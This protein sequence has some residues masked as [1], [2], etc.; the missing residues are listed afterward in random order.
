M[1]NRYWVGGTASWDGTAGTKW[2]ETSGGPGGASVP[3]VADD[4]FIDANS[5]VVTVTIATGNT[6]AKSINCTGFT[7]TVTG[8]ASITV[9][10]S[11]T[12][13]SAM[14]YT[15]TG[16]ML[17]I[18]TGTLTT[19][20]KTINGV[21]VNGDG[22][23][24]TLGSAL[25]SSN[26][27]VIDSG[28][29]DTGNYSVITTTLRSIGSAIR[30]INFGSS[31]ITLTSDACINFQNS[32]NLTL[33]AGTS[34]IFITA[35]NAEIQFIGNGQTF[36]NVNF[37]TQ[38]PLITIFD[39]N[40]F[41]NLS[42]QGRTT[43]GVSTTIFTANQTING[44]LTLSAGTNSS[45]RRVIASDVTGTI[46]TLTCN[47]VA[48][49][50]DIDFCDIAFAGN[51]ISGG[52][53][54]GT[55]LGNGK[56]NSNITF[57][58]PKT[59]YYRATGSANWGS[60]TSWSL[61]SGGTAT[62]AAFPLA[63]DSVIFPA[64][65]YPATGSTT[66]INGNY[67]VTTI[68]MSLRTA[69]TMSLSVLTGEGIG[70]VV[71]GN[72]ING[73][74]TTITNATSTVKF[75]GRTAQTITTAEKTFGASRSITIDSP[76]GSVTLNGALT[77]ATL[78]VT[79]GTFDTANFNV[80]ATSLS[81]SNT[82]VRTITLGSSVVE[83]LA[84]GSSINFTNSTNLTF[85][86]NT[87]QINLSASAAQLLGGGMTFYN[88]S[89]TNT[90]V[91]TRSI[92][93]E[94]T[95]NNL[96]LSTVSPGIAQLSIAADQIING[97]LTCAGSTALRRGFVSSNIVGTVRTI[98]AASISANDCDFRDITLAGAAAGAS[99]TRAG[100][101]GGNSGI[102]FPAP[103]TVYRVENITTWAGANSWSLTSGGNGSDNNF[104]L[105]QDTAVID[106]STT[107]TGT[108]AFGV[109]Y[110]VSAIDCSSRTSAI[111]LNHNVVQ[112]IYGSYTLGSGVTV[113]GTSQQTFSGRGTMAITSAGKTI[114]FPI[115]VETYG[116]TFQLND[117]FSS[118]NFVIIIAGAFDANNYNLSAT[119]YAANFPNTRTINM[120]S[121]LW[122]LS[123]A[124][125][126]AASAP[127][128]IN[129]TTGL[130]F[131]KGTANILLSNNTTSARVFIG[132]G[133]SYNKLT[134][135]GNTSTSI[136][137]ING[138]NSFTELASTKTVAHTVRFADS[139][140]TIDT[141]SITGTSG[142]V[143]TVDSS[144]AG[145]QCTFTLTNVTSGIDYLS[146]KDIGE[147]SGSKFYVGTNSTDGGNNSNV[148]FIATPSSTNFISLLGGL[149]I[150]EGI[151][152]S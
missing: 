65:T 79:Q 34:T 16:E 21:N 98:T 149:S 80:T 38:R 132:G 20:G 12:L 23:T 83:L 53:I 87:S 131:N 60:I 85:N 32:T 74:G 86:A 102:T 76:G 63:Q 142:N 2:S 8:S 3:T 18:G 96:T 47:N 95:F 13:V 104:P 61:T 144:V 70:L 56:G 68:D 27:I 108:L 101:C 71:L 99:P 120:G 48:A 73:T 69:N 44:T 136:L 127:W 89:F 92:T 105:A 5:G 15:H 33:N 28:N 137:T 22:I 112:T 41:N 62:A 29:F 113:S 42:F 37:S 4:V 52:N 97:A 50:T 36:Y 111:T 118:S 40:T 122:T 130:T 91:G 103:K 58:A 19:S 145:T 11:V 150:S 129:D 7:G 24:L 115:S 17:F 93:G 39:S 138:A 77:C 100:D 31:D 64:A 54:T 140:G 9:A 94:N 114:T 146:V 133:L 148:Y 128:S 30:T 119:R 82:N 106:N 6:G 116:G 126:G 67:L 46:R 109:R 151:T 51:C 135:G 88:V 134:I 141:W 59:V 152:I 143:V 66:T 1:A 35:T 139:Q 81:S 107:L 123:N 55:R 78:T 72:W 57:D 43:A 110:N 10:G 147:L 125:T 26:S 84:A 49:L 117:A 25:T 45:M 124:G 75:Q 90:S 14:T 121:G